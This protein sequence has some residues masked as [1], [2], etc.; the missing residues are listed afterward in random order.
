MVRP[1]RYTTESLEPPSA[2]DVA[3]WVETLERLWD[4][5]AFYQEQRGRCFERARAW[6]P[7]QLR[8]EAEAFFRR[9][10]GAA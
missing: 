6:E 10:A 2:E 8:G 1:D 3:G 4:D 7:V 9:V 5:E